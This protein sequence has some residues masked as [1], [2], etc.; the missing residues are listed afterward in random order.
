MCGMWYM[1]YNTTYN[2]E[3]K[4]KENRKQLTIVLNLF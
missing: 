2:T 3:I 4:F 1:K